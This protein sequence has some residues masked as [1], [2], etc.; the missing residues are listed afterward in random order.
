MHVEIYCRKSKTDNMVRK[1]LLLISQKAN[2][3]N[4]EKLRRKLP[5][6]QEKNGQNIWL[7][8]HKKG[9]KVILKGYSTH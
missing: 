3:F 7:T 5:T 9:H 6:T 4:I 1:R 8:V 2:I